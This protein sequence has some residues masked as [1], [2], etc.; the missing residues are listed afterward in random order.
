MKSKPTH[1]GLGIALGAALGAV[2]GVLAGHVA[3]WLGIG[4][5]IG[6]ALGSTMRSKAGNCP[7]CAELHHAHEAGRQAWQPAEKS[8]PQSR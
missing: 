6:M 2:F 4:V 3:V 8:G 1:T 5:A 7:Q